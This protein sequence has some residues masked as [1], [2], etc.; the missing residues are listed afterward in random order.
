MRT[1]LT[2]D[3]DLVARLKDE[4]HRRRVPFR[5][6]VN[7][8]IRRG[9]GGNRK[10]KRVKV[11]TFKT[12]LRPGFDPNGFNRLVDELEDEAFLAKLGARGR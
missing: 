12:T 10:K 11:R 9:L 8:A 1:T 7:D 3:D 6:V 4:V 2:L 5:D